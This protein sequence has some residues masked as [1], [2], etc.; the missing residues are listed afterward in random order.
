MDAS[1]K[2]N[3][4]SWI[5]FS[6]FLSSRI[7]HLYCT[8]NNLLPISIRT[9]LKYFPNVRQVWSKQTSPGPDL[10]TLSQGTQQFWECTT[11][12]HTVVQEHPYRTG[13]TKTGTRHEIRSGYDFMHTV[14]GPLHT[15]E[16]ECCH[17]CSASPYEGIA[18][19]NCRWELCQAG[20][21][22]PWMHVQQ[23][24]KEFS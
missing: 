23:Q 4:M 2:T 22:A 9:H 5:A 21:A 11:P 18:I 19:W 10:T 8:N 3:I 15:N 1:C 12:L 16:P 17:A 24:I 20:A 14:A 6:V 7:H 13:Q